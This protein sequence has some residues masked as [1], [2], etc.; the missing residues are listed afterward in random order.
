MGKTEGRKKGTAR[1]REAALASFFHRK[2]PKG[3]KREKW[4]AALS[5]LTGGKG[6]KR[7]QNPH[8]NKKKSHLLPTPS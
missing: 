7:K 2:K 5:A 8:R 3:T 1:G 4:I 6:G